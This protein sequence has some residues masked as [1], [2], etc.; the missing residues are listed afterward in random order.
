MIR[1]GP[2]DQNG[3]FTLGNLRPGEYLAFAMEEPEYGVWEDDAEWRKLESNA[4]KVSVRAGGTE[5]IALTV[6]K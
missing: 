4:K 3:M 6:I 2:I 1:S 5:T